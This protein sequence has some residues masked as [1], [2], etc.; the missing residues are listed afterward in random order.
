MKKSKPRS[1]FSAFLRKRAPIYLGLLA[2]FAVFI[3]PELTKGDL[4]SSLPELSESEQNVI[5]VL[6]SYDGP[7]YTGLTIL[8][9]LE[10]DIKQEYSNERIY[11]DKNTNVNLIVN[12]LQDTKY[13]VQ[14]DFETNKGNMYYD[15][16]V[17]LDD[18]EISGNNPKSKYIVELV[19]YY[20]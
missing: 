13:Q 19:D 10:L 6:M 20:D 3:V 7:N 9:A 16:N 18:I 5:D 11:V 15:W 17:T 12:K 2:L 4:A 1:S 14:L 8:D